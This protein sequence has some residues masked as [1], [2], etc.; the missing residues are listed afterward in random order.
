[1]KHRLFQNANYVL[2]TCGVLVGLLMYGISLAVERGFVD[3]AGSTMWLFFTGFLGGA[4]ILLGRVVSILHYWA[5]R[6]FL[7]DTWNRKYFSTRIKAELQHKEKFTHDLCLALVDM[8]DFKKVNDCYGH[9]FGDK[10][11]KKVADIL[12]KSTGGSDSIIRIGGDEFVIIFSQTNIAYAKLIAERIRKAVAEECN[13]VTVSIGVIEVGTTVH[14]SELMR[15]M[16]HMLYEG[17]KIKNS[18]T[19]MVMEA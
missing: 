12:K 11:I 5:Y 7:T 10:V 14:P 4:G 9:D 17:K 16:D 1:M 6:D 18:V 2:G 13:Y 19:T 15:E 3:I 8:D